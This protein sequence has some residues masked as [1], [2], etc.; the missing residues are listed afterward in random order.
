MEE[1]EYILKP[2]AQRLIKEAWHYKKQT[3]PY[4]HTTM[5]QM[6]PQQLLQELDVLNLKELRQIQG[7]GVPGSA[8]TYCNELIRKRL[9]EIDIIIK[10]QGREAF[11]HVETEVPPEVEQNGTTGV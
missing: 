7:C 5:E 8:W 1:N 6:D 3:R 4:V 9:D 10:K 2:L 11:A